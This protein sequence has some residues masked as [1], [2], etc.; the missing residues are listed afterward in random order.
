MVENDHNV[1]KLLKTLDDLGLADNTIVVYTSD[2]GAEM[3][4][5]PD[6]G[7]TP[8]R[9]EKAQNWEGAYRVPTLI[10]WPGV[11][12]PGTIFNQFFA[13]E[14]FLP[15]FAAAA[16]NPDIVQQCL[17]SCTSGDRSFHVHLDGYNLMPILSGQTT[18]SPRREFLYWS[19]DG[20]LFAIR[21]LNWK[22]IFMVSNS[23]GLG[24]WRDEFTRLRAPL[25]INLRSD[26][27]ERGPNSSWYDDWMARRAFL[28]VPAQAIVGQWLSSFKDFPPRQRPAAFN[29]D[30]VM[31][32]LTG[33]QQD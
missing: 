2:N 1:G 5:W 27:F 17:T 7:S 10:R 15:T 30:E 31:K 12:K 16:G 21:V 33:P 6:G 13:H 23:V 22:A 3:M 14:D 26:P 9:G 20:D 11:I 32:K 19:D 24:I 25:I 8:Y 18:E 28:L 29:L 4:S